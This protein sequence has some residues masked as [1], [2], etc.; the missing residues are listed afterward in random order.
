MAYQ[1]IHYETY[2]A[3]EARKEIG[4]GT[5][6]AGFCPHVA[7]PQQPKIL[8]GSTQGLAN[9][10]DVAKA[11]ARRL[12]TQ[13]T[14]SGEVKTFERPLRDTEN[15]VLFGVASWERTWSEQNPRLYE[16]SKKK[17]VKK[18]IRDYG[19][20]LQAVVFHDDEDQP[21]LHWWVL[22]K[23]CDISNVCPAFAAEKKFDKSR[24]KNT[25]KERAAVRLQA[26]KAFQLKWNREVFADAGL[27]KDGPK[28]RRL[29]RV[30]HKAESETLNIV[31]KAKLKADDTAKNLAGVSGALLMQNA[32]QKEQDARHKADLV[33]MDLRATAM[34]QGMTQAQRL[35]VAKQQKGAEAA[36]V[37]LGL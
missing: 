36:A 14:R 31:A 29:T 33:A 10:I 30:E 15:V 13:R 20:Q 32:K 25:G 34:V 27:T 11:S 5:R 23:N 8:Y 1:F 37:A 2:N 24:S 21:H 17:T 19:D 6:L 18:L 16:E 22:A 7:K 12:V 26:L 28:R 9:K 35:E 4:E 3:T